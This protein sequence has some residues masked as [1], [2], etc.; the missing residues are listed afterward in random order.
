[1]KLIV[2]VFI[3]CCQFLN[4]LGERQ[5][6]NMVPKL[7]FNNNHSGNTTLDKWR[8]VMQFTYGDV[9]PNITIPDGFVEGSNI[10]MN[11][12][13]TRVCFSEPPLSNRRL[14][15][16][17]W[18]MT[19]LYFKMPRSS[20]WIIETGPRFCANVEN[21]VCFAVSDDEGTHQWSFKVNMLYGNVVPK[22][23]PNKRVRNYCMKVDESKICF[24]KQPLLLN[25]DELLKSW[26]LNNILFNV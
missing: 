13:A 5:C 21:M 18:T 23:G 9:E 6:I 8:T 14:L 20:W 25:E 12:K 7:C 24:S 26:K 2:S 11:V 16:E 4:I 17:T 1:M 3:I 19:D 15:N 10:C 22:L